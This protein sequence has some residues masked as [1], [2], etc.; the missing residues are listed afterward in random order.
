MIDG[1]GGIMTATNILLIVGFIAVAI[2]YS[3]RINKRKGI[4]GELQEILISRGYAAF[5]KKLEEKTTRS[6]IKQKAR[7]LLQF[8]AAVDSKEFGE[9]DR[10]IPVL[11]RTPM[12]SKEF[13]RYNSKV[14]NLAV[15]QQDCQRGLMARNALRQKRIPEAIGT[16]AEMIYDIYIMHRS[17]HIDELLK[18]AETSKSPSARAMSYYRIAKQHYYLDDMEKARDYLIRAGSV[19]KNPTWQGIIKDIL[20]DN[21]Q[22]LK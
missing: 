8:D 17:N 18:L 15:E 21:C 11:N 5:S 7:D 3:Y 12:T 6:Y 20:Q 22:K 1:S 9:V 13:I 16:E 14:L 4:Q 19:Y 2:V 10:L